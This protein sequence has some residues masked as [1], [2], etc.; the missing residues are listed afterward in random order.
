LR[1]P[2]ADSDQEPKFEGATPVGLRRPHDRAPVV[3][4]RSRDVRLCYGL[5]VIE[6]HD[7]GKSRFRERRN[8]DRESGFALAVFNLHDASILASHAWE[9]R[10]RVGREQPRTEAR[11]DSEQVTTGQDSIDR[12]PSPLIRSARRGGG[13]A[14][15]PL[16]RGKV[17]G[18]G[19]RA[20]RPSP[21]PV[22]NAPDAD[23]H[24]RPPRPE[25]PA[26]TCPEAQ[27]A[28]R[29]TRPRID[30]KATPSVC[31]RASGP[32]RGRL[33]PRGND[34]DVR[35]QQRE[36]LETIRQERERLRDSAETA[37]AA[38]EQNR[39]AAEAARDA[40]VDGMRATADTLNATLEQMK[41][42][43]EMRRTL[44]EIRDV[45]KLACD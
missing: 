40:M 25:K 33:L 44:R 32:G 10:R 18:H 26:R 5:I 21:A 45:H 7:S 11:I 12:K 8:H 2:I 1:D 16:V 35:D 31:D 37:R 36:A 20:D 13:V 4:G 19:A 34:R 28:F 3:N 14:L 27:D 43:E 23:G 38:N 42:V 6:Y 17:S 29:S 15:R 24:P 30:G 39:G 9:V 41:V 22:D